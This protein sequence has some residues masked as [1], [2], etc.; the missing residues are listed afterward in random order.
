MRYSIINVAACCCLILT[1]GCLAFPTRASES[2][3]PLLGLSVQQGQ[4]LLQGKPYRG[5]GVNYFSLFYRTLNT[6]NRMAS[7]AQ[8]PLFVGEFGV[9]TKPDSAEEHQEFQELLNAIDLSMIPLAALWVFDHPGQNR[10]WNITFDNERHTM[11]ERLG[12]INR[13]YNK[14]RD[15]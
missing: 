11:L 9:S 10:D 1:V 14:E 15:R 13:H 3:L 4:L 12:M 7:T 5:I 8:K 6:L 2:N